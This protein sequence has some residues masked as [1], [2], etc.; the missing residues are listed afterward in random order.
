[1]LII[2]SLLSLARFIVKFCKIQKLIDYDSK[3]VFCGTEF[4]NCFYKSRIYL[5]FG[6]S[7]TL[8]DCN[9]QN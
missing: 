2:L 1:M 4:K 3:T 5:G 9:N 7:L 6:Y 8:M